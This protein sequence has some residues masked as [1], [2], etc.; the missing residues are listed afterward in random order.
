MPISFFVQKTDRIR[1]PVYVYTKGDNVEATHLQN[2]VPKDIVGEQQVINFMF[3]KPSHIDS[4]NI[5]RQAQI[6][7]RG[8]DDT[9]LDLVAFSDGILKTLLKE[10]DL[11]E[12]DEVMKVSI[13]NINNLVPSIAKAAVAG[14]LEK[15]Q[16]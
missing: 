2:E 1:I 7:L 9:S 15:V 10:W 11:K 3:S 14:L 4:S 6:K 13:V 16:L 8:S 12:G 5:I